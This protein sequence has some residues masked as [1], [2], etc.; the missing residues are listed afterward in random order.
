[1]FIRATLLSDVLSSYDTVDVILVTA[2]MIDAVATEI[3][4]TPADALA[5]TELLDRHTVVSTPLPDTRTCT[6]PSL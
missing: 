2:S 4:A 1:M 5:T 6:L 3:A